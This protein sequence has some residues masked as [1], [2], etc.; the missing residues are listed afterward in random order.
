VRLVAPEIFDV[1]KVG[2]SAEEVGEVLHHTHVVALGA[3]A[4]TP[5]EHVLDEP[6]A[7]VRGEFERH[8]TLL[9]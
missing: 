3:F 8:L 9:L 4:V 5:D 6:L 1:G 7:H 2:R